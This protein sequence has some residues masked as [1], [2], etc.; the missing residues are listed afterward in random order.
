MQLN[1]IH[2]EEHREEMEGGGDKGQREESNSISSVWSQQEAARYE[3]GPA[4][5]GVCS[6]NLHELCCLPKQFI[7]SEIYIKN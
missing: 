7:T 3:T 1:R 2:S 6:Q 5:A 4:A